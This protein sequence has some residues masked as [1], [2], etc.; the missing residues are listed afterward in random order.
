MSHNDDWVQVELEEEKAKALQTS[1]EDWREDPELTE[2]ERAKTLA[3][4]EALVKELEAGGFNDEPEF[5]GK[6]LRVNELKPEMYEK[7]FTPAAL[8]AISLWSKTTIHQ[9]NAVVGRSTEFDKDGY[10]EE[11]THFERKFAPLLVVA[12]TI[13]SPDMLD[14]ALSEMGLVVSGLAHRGY[15]TSHLTMPSAIE[16]VCPNCSLWN[17]DDVVEPAHTC[18]ERQCVFMFVHCRS[19]Y[20]EIA[21]KFHPMVVP[22]GCVGP[23][24]EDLM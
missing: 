22:E 6:A 10:R 7:Y 15:L 8:K 20:F 5:H 17:L 1:L 24:L 23:R 12:C 11:S 19:E 18:V 13:D 2:E 4:L 9:Y 14:S 16:L 3:D 21:S